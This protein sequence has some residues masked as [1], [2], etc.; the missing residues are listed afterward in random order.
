MI[1][2]VD[3]PSNT[4]KRRNYV[5]DHSAQSGEDERLSFS[6]S[7]GATLTQQPLD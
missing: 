5:P 7:C 4:Q 3:L 1:F 2:E 6:F